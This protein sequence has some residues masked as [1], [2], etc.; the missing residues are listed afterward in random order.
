MIEPESLCGERDNTPEPRYPRRRDAE[1][2]PYA[3]CGSSQGYQTFTP[4]FHI[5]IFYMGA[6]V[7]LELTKTSVRLLD[8]GADLD[9]VEF[10]IQSAFNRVT[11]D[12]A[13]SPVG[14]GQATGSLVPLLTAS[15]DQE[16]QFISAMYAILVE[17]KDGNADNRH[18][19][20]VKL[21]F[22]TQGVITVMSLTFFRSE[23]RDRRRD[24]HSNPSKLAMSK[25]APQL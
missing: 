24:S 16:D 19:P 23:H 1:A 13:S 11:W 8:S 17:L 9:E 4:L 5:K 10:K 3:A 22:R 21:A 25:P 12:I 2:A 6:Q 14:G 18:M 7:G 15:E 20:A